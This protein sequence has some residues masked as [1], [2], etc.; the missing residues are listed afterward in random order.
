ME[1]FGEWL[2]RLST[3]RHTELIALLNGIIHHHDDPVILMDVG[4]ADQVAP[5]E[6]SVGKTYLS[7]CN[8][9]RRRLASAEV[10]PITLGSARK[11]QL[12]KNSGIFSIES[13]SSCPIR[14]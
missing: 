1:G 13:A 11:M 4:L 3:S 10:V 7:W 2:C 6:M 9:G 14:A 8:R 12:F 5:R